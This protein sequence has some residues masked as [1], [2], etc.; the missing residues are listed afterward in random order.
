MSFD[1]IITV[2]ASIATCVTAVIILF[3]LIEMKTQRNMS[4][5]PA[6]VPT[7]QI[8]S[9]QKDSGHYYWQDKSTDQKESTN[10]ILNYPLHIFNGA[11]KNINVKWQFDI[12]NVV[13][14][15]NSLFQKNMTKTYIEI[16]KKNWLHLRGDDSNALSLSI[17]HDMERNYDHLLPASIDKAGISVHVPKTFVTLVSHYFHEAGKHIN[18][19]D[20][21]LSNVPNIE[22]FLTFEDIGGT[23]HAIKYRL[24]ISL[25]TFTD[26]KFHASLEYKTIS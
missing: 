21:W 3:T 10:K 26:S 20:S 18:K 24:L 8:I 22:L 14:S 7:S 4:Y 1:Q 23:K 11:A 12:Q 16:S 25:N 6:L 19:D 5:K 13:D 9:A 2:F 15:V 17:D